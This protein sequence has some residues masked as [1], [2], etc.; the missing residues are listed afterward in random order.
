MCQ[1]QWLHYED[2][3][4]HCVMQSRDVSNTEENDTHPFIH[5]FI[6]FN[7]MNPLQGPRHLSDT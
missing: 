6:L 1:N 5:S 4:T 7:S 2:T 3:K